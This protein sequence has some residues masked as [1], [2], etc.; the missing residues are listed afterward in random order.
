MRNTATVLEDRASSSELS[1]VPEDFKSM[2]VD[3]DDVEEPQSKKRKRN[4]CHCAED[5]QEFA[6]DWTTQQYKRDDVRVTLPSLPHDSK[7][8]STAI[9]RTFLP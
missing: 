2:A 3:D 1:D 7:S 8:P 9:R 5:A 4:K 6:T